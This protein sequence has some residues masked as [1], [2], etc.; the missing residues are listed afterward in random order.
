MISLF[1]VHVFSDSSGVFCINMIPRRANCTISG[2]Q[3]VDSMDEFYEEIDGLGYVTLEIVKRSYD[4]LFIDYMKL[5]C[6]SLIIISNND[7]ILMNVDSFPTYTRLLHI[8]F[9]NVTVEPLY[10]GQYTS[11][12]IK[13]AEFVNSFLS[14]RYSDPPKLIMDSFVGSLR[15]IDSFLVFSIREM[16]VYTDGLDTFPRYP[17]NIVI[18]GETFDTYTRVFLVSVPSFT[19]DVFS[20]HFSVFYPNH[21]VVNVSCIQEALVEFCFSGDSVD[22]VCN[23][24]LNSPPSFSLDFQFSIPNSFVFKSTTRTLFNISVYRFKFDYPSF[25]Y[26]DGSHFPAEFSLMHHNYSFCTSKAISSIHLLDASSSLIHFVSAL[27]QTILYFRDGSIGN[28]VVMD[29]N[30]SLDLKFRCLLTTAVDKS[31]I[32]DPKINVSI[33]TY[34]YQS[35]LLVV[36]NMFFGKHTQFM[37]E[38]Y[39]SK[40]P[41]LSG[42]TLTSFN[43]DFNVTFRL[44]QKQSLA[45][46]VFKNYINRKFDIV[47]APN[48]K[49]QN[50]S[51][52]FPASNPIGFNSKHPL[53]EYVCTNSGENKCF[54]IIPKGYP[55]RI[56]IKICISDLK[57]KCQK[58]RK[59]ISLE[60]FS[61]W[62]KSSESYTDTIDISIMCTM[63]NVF[64]LSSLPHQI[65]N[66]IISTEE[67]S[68]Y[69]QNTVH[70]DVSPPSQMMVKR[71][72]VENMNVQFYP[73]NKNITLSF[74]ALNIS[75]N[76]NIFNINS[77]S[78]DPSMDLYVSMLSI[79]IIPIKYL[80]RVSAYLGHESIHIYYKSEGW[81]FSY[82]TKVS[83]VSFTPPPNV[84]PKCIYSDFIMNITIDVFADVLHP[85]SLQIESRSFTK[86]GDFITI[87]SIQMQNYQEILLTIIGSEQVSIETSCHYIPIRIIKA[88]WIVL[89]NPKPTS[90]PITLSPQVFD[91][92]TLIVLGSQNQ[93]YNL[94]SITLIGEAS[95]FCDP[96][97]RN[98]KSQVKILGLAVDNMSICSV[99]NAWIQGRIEIPATSKLTLSDCD[100]SNTIILSKVIVGESYSQLFV[101][102]KRLADTLPMGFA[103]SSSP[104]NQKSDSVV[105]YNIVEAPSKTMASQLRN[106]LMLLPPQISINSST[107]E[108]SIKDNSG[109]Y[110][111]V[112]YSPI[113]ETEKK[114]TVEG[115]VY[116]TILVSIIVV[117]VFAATTFII[118]RRRTQNMMDKEMKSLR[119]DS[120][121]YMN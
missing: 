113:E 26:C 20:S 109:R 70:I 38:Y 62:A 118:V 107:I 89:D 69:V 60:N 99:E 77:I 91:Q 11:I 41:F 55:S 68:L 57:A 36:D 98:S 50:W 46:S 10:S 119:G 104:S 61:D 6:R 93:V 63:S 101:I 114:N 66:L 59:Y 32:I 43:D 31:S 37:L 45:D 121:I 90:T 7:E 56:I 27:S 87:N 92:N 2:Y 23:S 117:V 86:Q 47:C 19:I 34:L 49:C 78:M 75:K 85:R 42:N 16:M 111:V 67:L 116:I 95:L 21:V 80:Q 5:N 35:G 58:N 64:N 8:K 14:F 79:N 73:N 120:M 33:V 81:T 96:Y 108:V 24:Y 12:Y 94:K 48:L 83:G 30:Y 115:I 97:R 88:S 102:T 28:N 54:S 15:A 65:N 106:L 82:G 1:L 103:I 52:I 13:S 18:S 74:E 3:I 44:N 53:L 9:V 72:T 22:Y 17:M 29:T 40:P 76:V 4:L 25:I 51:M 110:V 71:L 39:F 84:F 112:E 100:I 105:S